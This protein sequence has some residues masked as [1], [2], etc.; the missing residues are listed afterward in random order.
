MFKTLTT[1]LR[2]RAADAGEA[3]TDAQAIPLLRQQLRDATV[4]LE[5]AQRA[6]A[7]VVAYHKREEKRAGEIA[8]QLADLETRTLE[9]LERGEETLAREAAGAIAELEQERDA[10]AAVLTNYS[11]EIG[12]LRDDVMLAQKRLK[13][14]QRGKNLADA[15]AKTQKLRGT[16]PNGVMASLKEA[17]DTLA[18]LQA[19]QIHAADAATAFED[20]SAEGSAES[21]S[22]RLADAGCGPQ[23]HADAASV[24]A[25][26]RTRMAEQPA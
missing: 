15:T 1:L 17:E 2:G 16:V 22:D 26:L 25:R 7:V 13:A 5:T 21:I 4:G 10:T 20:L 24:L 18:R 14:L 3:L 19:R 11:A 23:K 12:R 8:A 9:A 6:V